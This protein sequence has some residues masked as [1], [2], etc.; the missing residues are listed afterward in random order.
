MAIIYD[1]KKKLAIDFGELIEKAVLPSDL[2]FG[3]PTAAPAAIGNASMVEITHPASGEKR[4]LVYN[5]ANLST[6][7]ENITPGRLVLSLSEPLTSTRDVAV[8]FGETYGV[9]IKPEDVN[10]VELNVGS[11]ILRV[12]ASPESLAY[13]GSVSFLLYN[14]GTEGGL[15]PPTNDF[16]FENNAVNTGTSG[17]DMTIPF[18]YT[19]SNG[20]TWAHVPA[21]GPMLFGNDCKI[22]ACGDY[23]I[24]FELFLNQNYS[25]YLY[26]FTNNPSGTGSS[27]TIGTL[28]FHAR[29]LYEY[30]VTP[31]N[32]PL[33]SAGETTIPYDRPVRITI[34]SRNGYSSIWL[35]GVLKMVYPALQ[36]SAQNFLV[37][38]R[39]GDGSAA[40]MPNAIGIANLRSW[41]IGLDNDQLDKLFGKTPDPLK[42]RNFWPLNNNNWDMGREAFPWLP[43]MG[44]T[45]YGDRFWANSNA[46]TGAAIGTFFDVSRDYTLQFKV[47]NPTSAFGD[48]EG[49]FTTSGLGDVNHA[50]KLCQGNF[51]LGGSNETFTT[52]QKLTYREQRTVTLR[53]TGDVYEMW[54]DE[55]Y[56][57]TCSVPVHSTFLT[58]FGKANQALGTAW[59]FADIKF[60]DRSLS[61]AEL[62]QLV[63]P[64]LQQLTPVLGLLNTSGNTQMIDGNLSTLFNVTA[65]PTA[66][67]SLGAQ[68]AGK[69]MFGAYYYFAAD[70]INY[71][72][73]LKEI[74]LDKWQSGAWVAKQ[75]QYTQYVRQIYPTRD[76]ILYTN[77]TQ[78]D[79]TDLRVRL[80]GVGN[81]NDPNGYRWC[82]ELV[83]MLGDQPELLFPCAASDAALTGITGD[84]ALLDGDNIYGWTAYSAAREGVVEATLPDSFIGRQLRRLDIRFLTDSANWD[85]KAKYISVDTWDGSKWVE[86]VKVATAKSALNAPQN[87]SINLPTP[88][89]FTNAKM[90]LRCSEH[91]GNAS[92][93]VSLVDI[94]PM[95]GDPRP[96]SE[97]ITPTPLY[98]FGA[99]GSLE[100]TGSQDALALSPEQFSV[101]DYNGEKWLGIKQGTWA[102]LPVDLAIDKDF[103][104]DFMVVAEPLVSDGNYGT[105]L[106]SASGLP[107]SGPFPAGT[108]VTWRGI[109][110]E[111]KNTLALS[112]MGYSGAS[113]SLWRPALSRTPTRVT[114]RRTG[115]RFDWY[116]NGNLVWSFTNTT[117]PAAW[118]YFGTPV[119]RTQ[120][121]RKLR[122]YDRSMSDSELAE[123]FTK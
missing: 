58:H 7:F 15:P 4:T 35:D 47:F 115:D 22:K 51:Y 123:L 63:G 87:E 65:N 72:K 69:W 74:Y 90:R 13:E 92:G 120:L 27:N 98:E 42:P 50:V 93:L 104:V 37:A 103:T 34:R 71:L 95:F 102:Q 96:K 82:T 16:K 18:N 52:R 89:T 105:L 33:W 11:Y 108:L 10:Q 38:F 111:V 14:G 56:L 107:Y 1:F 44:F 109:T 119:A 118:R 100:N 61:I 21:G 30:L 32:S 88:I 19:Q 73:K 36:E 43:S 101:T 55:H 75:G 62:R 79:T 70:S 122:Y 67:G 17:L 66:I 23:T 112:N 41:D 121:F 78:V 20:R 57:G 8:K 5:R 86:A 53:R 85:K 116:A 54:I 39:N 97:K 40:Q 2:V 77:P 59:F 110:P 28:A 26:T 12:E 45:N 64:N 68:W 80:R 106:S 6:I 94:N 99:Y 25:G 48:V 46:P 29:R 31:T 49:I 24:D 113:D 117:K 84:T 91:N 3:V 83:L 9:P 60:W 81:W 76:M 114:L